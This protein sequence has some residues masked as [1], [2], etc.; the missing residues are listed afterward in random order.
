[1][2]IRLGM[3]DPPSLMKYNMLGKSSLK[4]AASTALNRKAAAE[5]MVLLVNKKTASGSPLLP[6]D[7]TSLAG[8]AGSV[9]V[10]GPVADNGNNT[11]GN[12]ACNPGNCSTNITSILGG[13]R[14]AGTGLS[15]SEVTYVPGC[16]TTSCHETDFSAAVS[17]AGKAKLAVLVLGLL[18]W[19]MQQDGPNPDPNAFEH[20]GHD[21]T[22]IAL[23]A[24]QVRVL[25][26]YSPRYVTVCG[27]SPY[28]SLPNDE[29][30]RSTSWRVISQGIVR[31]VPS[32][33]C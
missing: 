3:F 24:N 26:P 22:S 20:E 7:A 8:T 32:F 6:L 21:R 30:A 13:L 2:R 17:A 14:N 28:D 18:G 5:G 31:R 23:P 19:D 9:L 4:T 29:V 10:A 12:Y 25:F 27:L 15:K 33:A 11:L 16:I 1:M